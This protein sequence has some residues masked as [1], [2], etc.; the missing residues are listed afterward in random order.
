MERSFD[1]LDEMTRYSI[2]ENG[3][4]L[5]SISD[6]VAASDVKMQFA[7]TKFSD[8]FDRLSTSEKV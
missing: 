4:G 1:L 7:D 2:K 5:S 6:A 3:E 8:S